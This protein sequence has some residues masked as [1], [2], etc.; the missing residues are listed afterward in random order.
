MVSEILKQLRESHGMTQAQLS[1]LLEIERSTY[2]YY[3]TGRV[4]GLEILVKLARIYQVSLDYL[5]LRE[6]AD[7]DFFFASPY[8]EEEQAQNLHLSPDEKKMLYL[9]RLCD[10]KNAVLEFIRNKNLEAAE[11]ED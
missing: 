3:E 8:P 11:T 6:E 10:D 9:Y 2:A 1:N 4:P 7:P 5:A